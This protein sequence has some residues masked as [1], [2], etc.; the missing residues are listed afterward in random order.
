MRASTDVVAALMISQSTGFI[1][2][3]FDFAVLS[4]KIVDNQYLCIDTAIGRI[5]KH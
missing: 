2:F 1:V 3:L 5:S 4:S